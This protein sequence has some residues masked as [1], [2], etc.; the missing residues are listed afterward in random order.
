LMGPELPVPPPPS[1]LATAPKRNVK[2]VWSLILG[3]AGIWP[4]V[5]IGSIAALIL[6]SIAKGEIERSGGYQSGRGL[7]PAGIALGWVGAGMLALAVAIG[8]A[9]GLEM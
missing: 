6:G 5:F 9:G 3:I 7:S 4:L 2:A 1:T 8:L